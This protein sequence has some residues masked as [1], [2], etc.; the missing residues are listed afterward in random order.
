MYFNCLMS[1]DVAEWDDKLV[2]YWGTFCVQC[3]FYFL[4]ECEQCVKSKMK[5]KQNGRET[6][7]TVSGCCVWTE[8]HV[9]GRN[10]AIRWPEALQC[11]QACWPRWLSTSHSSLSRSCSWSE[12][13]NNWQRSL[14]GKLLHFVFWL[15]G[16]VY[17]SVPT[18]CLP[19]LVWNVSK[20]TIWS[21]WQ[22]FFCDICV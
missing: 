18:F 8:A 12:I 10:N 5:P 1:P 13:S 11:A 20:W 14:L 17:T 7:E 2:I 4:W 19:T 22:I 15:I 6:D 21:H 9:C 3:I 16:S